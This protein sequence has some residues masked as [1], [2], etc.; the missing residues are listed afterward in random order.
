MP[1]IQ[2]NGI[3]LYFEDTGSGDPLLLI[4]GVG[5]NTLGWGPL[6]P[7]LAGR[8]RV[9]TFDNRGAGRS[10]AP[11]GP[12]STQQLAD[13]AVALLDDLGVARAHVLGMSFGGTIAQELALASPGRIDRLV[14]FATHAF[15][16]PGFWGPWSTFLVQ[17]A[18][19][20]LDRA[21]SALW[22]MA[23]M[24]TPTVMAQH[25]WVETVLA[26][27]LNNPYPAPVHGLKAQVGA[28]QAHDSR[29]RLAQIAAPT[30]VLVGAED[31]ITP[32]ADARELA[33]G[34]PGARLQ[35]LERGGHLAHLEYP[36]V[37]ADALLAFLS[38]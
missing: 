13:D 23:W 32:V 27:R 7:P 8:F 17:A 29:S 28:S 11:S 38:G 3:E 31:I 36:E 5:A 9:I 33:E 10:S 16:R 35:V 34:I 30:L 18:E 2:V 1:R 15:P 22:S 20:G 19:Q 12:Y 26:K 21:G 6:L 37:V 4:S 24:F 14:L 25:D